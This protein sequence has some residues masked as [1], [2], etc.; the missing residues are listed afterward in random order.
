MEEVEQARTKMLEMNLNWPETQTFAEEALLCLSDRRQSVET[1]CQG[2]PKRKEIVQTFPFAE[3]TFLCR[4]RPSKKMKMCR[5]ESEAVVVEGDMVGNDLPKQD[6]R[7]GKPKRKEVTVTD[8]RENVQGKSASLRRCRKRAL[9][10]W[11]GQQERREQLI[12]S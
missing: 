10:T 12:R 1:V 5:E 2:K 4:G 11:A 8:D 3:E 7:Q 6:H 9:S